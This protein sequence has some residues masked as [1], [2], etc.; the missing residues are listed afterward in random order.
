MARGRRQAATIAPG[1]ALG[2]ALCGAL[3]FGLAGGVAEAHIVY[4]TKTLRE[5]VAEADL[6]VRARIVG[7]ES[8]APRSSDEPSAD[9]PS[10]DA[11]VL[12]VLKGSW[13]QRSLRFVQHG[14]G[15]ARFEPGEEVL[16]FLLE[17]GR[18]R[19]LAALAETRAEQ[20]VSL[21]EHDQKYALT[22]ATRAALLSAT[23]SYASGA[24]VGSDALRSA[25]LALLS[26][27]DADLAASALRDM[28]ASPAGNLVRP[29]DL[30]AL[31]RVIADTQSPM[32]VRAALLVELERRQLIDGSEHWRR[33]LSDQVPDGDLVVAVR[34]AG[35]ARDPAV[36]KR[37]VAL[38]SDSRDEVAVA[39]ALALGQ[40]GS[41]VEPLE[42]AL[43]SASP[44]VRSAAVRALAQIG[45]AEAVRSLAL[46]GRRHP[47]PTTRRLAR[48]AASRVR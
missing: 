22:P 31:E 15:V 19:E 4:G 41:S 33:L 27:G 28:V 16:L 43:E 20:W 46:A 25:T 11:A 9:R 18:S 5:L 24:P 48:A 44:R 2:L 37:L 7:T 10:V 39:A 3:V 12:E 38:L 13:E 45:T 36:R 40:P 32:S 6:V 26:S 1:L 30:P 34:A 47:D 14:H 35:G 21:Q 42:A 8:V 23:R 29:A 17:I